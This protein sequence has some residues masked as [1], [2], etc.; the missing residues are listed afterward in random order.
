M[1]L[2]LR[3]VAALALPLTLAACSG[4]MDDEQS[5]AGTAPVV[6]DAGTEITDAGTDALPTSFSADMLEG[7]TIYSVAFEEDAVT[8]HDYFSL[9]FASGSYTYR[10]DIFGDE[11]TGA[12]QIENGV[13]V[14]QSS[15]P[16]HVSLLSASEGKWRV[17]FAEDGDEF[18][19]DW[20]LDRADAEAEMAKVRMLPTASITVDGQFDD[21]AEVPAIESPA[22]PTVIDLKAVRFAKDGTYLYF[23][24]E[25]D[26]P[27]TDFLPGQDE[28][29][30]SNVLWINF[31]GVDHTEV[32]TNSPDLDSAWLGNGR[33]A[34]S[35]GQFVVNGEQMEGRIP[36][37][38]FR[39]NYASMSVEFGVDDPN[40]EDEDEDDY[41]IEVVHPLFRR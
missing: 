31:N 18:E 14:I 9:S 22:T 26:R 6:T 33:F 37:S 39:P 32:G 23:L 13:V 12:F 21:W 30:W 25:A 27:I 40:G 19:A 10:N 11:G 16:T 20:Y 3:F 36:L 15:P 28:K 38:L 29:G 41:H 1:K 24:I 5:D 8:V 2:N 4:R 7:R 34:D 17:K 35:G